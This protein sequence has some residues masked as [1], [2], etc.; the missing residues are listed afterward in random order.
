MKSASSVTCSRWGR[1]IGL[2]GCPEIVKRGYVALLDH[3]HAAVADEDAAA[4]RVEFGVF[5]DHIAELIQ[6]AVEN[7]T[8]ALGLVD[9][10]L[11][12]RDC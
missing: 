10:E 4:G 7:H 6:P 1:P 3:E 8:V 12:L 9:F 5:R 2:F 11:M